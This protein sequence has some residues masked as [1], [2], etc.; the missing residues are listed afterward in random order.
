ME[1]RMNGP[2]VEVFVIWLGSFIPRYDEMT[3]TRPCWES[4]ICQS[5]HFPQIREPRNKREMH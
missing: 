2:R 4:D 5:M 1:S 3:Q